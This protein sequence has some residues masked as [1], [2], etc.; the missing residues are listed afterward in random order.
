MHSFTQSQIA[1]ILGICLGLNLPNPTNIAEWDGT[2]LDSFRAGKL[3][4]Q[5]IAARNSSDVK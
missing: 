2:H 4:F 1:M 5:D 3:M